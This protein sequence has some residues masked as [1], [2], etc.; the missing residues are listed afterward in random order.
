MSDQS[1]VV[2]ESLGS[3]DITLTVA[4]RYLR[5]AQGVQNRMEE[6]SRR[7]GSDVSL[8]SVEPVTSYST[9]GTGG[10]VQGLGLKF[11]VW[12]LGVGVQGLVFHAWYRGW[13][14]GVEIYALR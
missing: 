2:E 10:G 11:R 5:R 14:S 1:R 8:R 9:R 7:V 12:S 3:V 6:Q 4:A 13:E